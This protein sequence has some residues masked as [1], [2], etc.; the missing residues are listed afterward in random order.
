MSHTP[1]TA[2]LR[3]LVADDD[4]MATRILTAA[5]KPWPFDVV[6]VHDGEAAWAHL[7]AERPQIAI[8]DWEMPGAD[9][10]EL[11]RRARQTP[12]CA[13]TYIILLT[14]R[15]GRS[16][17]IEGLG[18]GADDYVTKPFDREEF[19]VRIQVGARVTALQQRLAE[20]VEELQ[21]AL[22]NVRQLEGFIAICSYCKRIR[23]DEQQWEQM[24]RYITD[25]SHAHFSHGV[26]PTCFEK[27]K[28]EWGG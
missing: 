22:A 13:G 10:P 3:V 9:G 28:K 11:C 15:E 4:R 14:G 19:L 5:L 23:S 25:H 12:E 26:C 21:L 6:T 7:L 1:Q 17:L 18:A 2:P 27:V 8:L 24:E 20:R 16:N